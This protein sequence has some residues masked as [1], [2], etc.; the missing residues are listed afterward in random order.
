MDEVRRKGLSRGWTTGACAAAAAKAAVS[1]LMGQGF[2]D[3]VTIRL[4]KGQSPSFP[5]SRQET[6]KGWARAGVI[7]DA[8]DDPD[9]THGA[10]IVA[11]VRRLP[12]GGGL[13][14]KA[15]EGVGRVTLP[16]LPAAV[17]QPAINPG[18]QAQIRENLAPFGQ[19]FEVTLSIPG[20]RALAAKTLNA[21]LGILGGLSILGTTGVV[22]PYSSAAW[23][24][25]VHRAIDVARA[26]GLRHL[27]GSTGKT[28]EAGVARLYGLPELALIDMGGFAGALLKYLKRHPVARVTL[29]GGFAK[30]AKLA[31]GARDLHSKQSQVDAGFLADLLKEAGAPRAL[32][33]AARQSASAAQIL[34]LAHAVPLA[35]IVAERARASGLEILGDAASLDIAVFDRKGKLIG[36]AA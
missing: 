18:P 31:A 10:E 9:V 27:A 23:I 17:G 24:G 28:S 20:G 36:H 22:T 8:G 15:G 26:A 1:A 11:Q 6:G 14:F 35:Q 21:R 32:V 16:G 4:P 12:K 3:P 33:R 30:M 34:E 5:L 29:A 7:K 19:D 13:V 25:A 2:P